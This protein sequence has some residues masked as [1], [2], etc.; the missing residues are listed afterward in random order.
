M[1]AMKILLLLLSCEVTLT[2]PTM[3]RNEYNARPNMSNSRFKRPLLTNR[4]EKIPH[5][6]SRE[7]ARFLTI[8]DRRNPIALIVELVTNTT[9]NMRISDLKSRNNS[10]AESAALSCFLTNFSS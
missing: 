3:K 7:A 6:V 4:E 8:P 5:G 2:F 9:R 1:I 10:F